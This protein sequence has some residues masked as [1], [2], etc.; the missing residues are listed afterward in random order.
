[1]LDQGAILG[2]KH[3]TITD[4]R[5]IKLS[6][7][8]V[9]EK[10]EIPDGLKDISKIIAYDIK[11]GLID[12][13][14]SQF[15]IVKD[16]LGKEIGVEE[17]IDEILRYKPSPGER[18]DL[19]DEKNIGWAKFLIWCIEYGRVKGD[20][21]VFVKDNTV[22]LINSASPEPFLFLPFEYM[23]I[24]TE[25]EKIVPE[26][27]ILHPIYFDLVQDKESLK[28]KLVEHK[29][30]FDSVVHKM[31]KVKMKKGKLKEILIDE[32]M[33]LKGKDHEI[34]T[35]D[36]AII[37]TLPFLES[38]IIGRISQV[39][40]RA[41]KFI[42]FILEV[43]CKR[44]ETWGKPIEVTCSCGKSHKILPAV[45]LANIKCDS[46]VP[47]QKGEEEQYVPREATRENIEKLLSTEE[48]SEIIK[49]DTGIDLFSHLGFD[50][51]DLKIKRKSVESDIEEKKLRDNFAQVV[52]RVD[53]LKLIQYPEERIEDMVL[54]IEEIAEN[55]RKA[56]E[57]QTVGR[58]VEGVIK[59]ILEAEGINV[60]PIYAGA[61]I[62]IWPEEEGC[63]FGEVKIYPYLIEIKFTSGN[64]V[65]FSKTQAKKALETG[66]NYFILVIGGDIYLKQKLLK[67]DHLSIEE[68][69]E[70]KKLIEQKSFL[71]H[72]I[73]E[74]LIKP[75]FP[76][77]VEPD[78]N[79]YWIK[80]IL[81]TRWENLRDWILKTYKKETFV[82]HT[83]DTHEHE[84]NKV[85]SYQEKKSGVP[86][87]DMS[88]DE[89]KEAIES[90]GDMKKLNVLWDIARKKK[91]D[92]L[93]GRATERMMEK[94]RW[95]KGRK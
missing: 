38:E 92:D 61:D 19:K 46:W 87:S 55:Q 86:R 62:E 27:R 57:N 52:D 88:Y 48:I 47:V 53:I 2:P 81:W 63:D 45:W 11:S 31:R 54:Q 85:F 36:G 8:L 79:G 4:I 56:R 78:I 7:D 91:Y 93:A 76:E 35:P 40:E 69:K 33:E 17:I 24:D 26:G 44:D 22:K 14:F 70:I 28:N 20:M 89:L 77:G 25:Y 29:L 41:K 6:K 58:N 49:S 95:F 84:N 90:A 32:D 30:C 67:Y 64:R 75:P 83:E 59:E 51:L 66:E 71:I 1:M 94:R 42:C 82:T 65:R 73:S 39:P 50:S 72:G 9:L 34:T 68:K 13:E 23:D 16:F 15:K 43:V 5:D 21:P 80:E 74:K 10:G 3:F 18:V 12:K 60:T 37:T